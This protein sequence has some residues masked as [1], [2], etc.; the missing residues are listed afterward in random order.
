MGSHR[1]FYLPNGYCVATLSPH[2]RT[3][4]V[5][6]PGSAGRVG[7]VAKSLFMRWKLFLG[8]AAACFLDSDQAEKKIMED[9]QRWAMRSWEGF[10]RH[11]SAGLKNTDVWVGEDEHFTPAH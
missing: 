7:E 9:E 6:G 3:N 1:S 10:F 11:S 4:T 2:R 5:V 8:K